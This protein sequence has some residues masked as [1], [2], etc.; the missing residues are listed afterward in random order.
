METILHY[1]P[2]IN[3]TGRKLVQMSERLQGCCQQP[4]LTCSNLQSL[5]H[6]PMRGQRE[7][8]PLSLTLHCMSSDLRSSRILAWTASSFQPI[9][10]LMGNAVLFGASILRADSA[11]VA[12][13]HAKLQ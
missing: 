8:Q 1:D 2:T 10:R 9:M 7:C 5:R 12:Q 6:G 11:Y 4:A 13:A 3:Q